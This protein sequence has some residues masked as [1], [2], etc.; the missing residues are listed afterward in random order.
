MFA[1]KTQVEHIEPVF[2]WKKNH[3]VS[4][5]GKDGLVAYERVGG[6]VLGCQAKPSAL[7]IKEKQWLILLFTPIKREEGRETE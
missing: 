5:A 1:G 4:L 6:W 3:G 7:L 2:Q